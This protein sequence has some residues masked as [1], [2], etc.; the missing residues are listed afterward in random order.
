MVAYYLLYWE[1][2]SMTDAHLTVCKWVIGG[3]RLQCRS[4][5]IFCPVSQVE[6]KHFALDC[7]WLISDLHVDQV[8]CIPLH[9]LFEQSHQWVVHRGWFSPETCGVWYQTQ[10]MSAYRLHIWRDH[11]KLSWC[12][13]QVCAQVLQDKSNVIPTTTPPVLS[14]HI[15]VKLWA[16]ISNIS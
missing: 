1:D 5:V 8:I 6:W 3:C 16:V 4:W 15:C 11:S 14:Q 12:W 10:I 13:G 9:G 7:T 2:C